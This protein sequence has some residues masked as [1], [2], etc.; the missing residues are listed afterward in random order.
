MRSAR[1]QLTAHDGG[2]DIALGKATAKSE[3]KD[4]IDILLKASFSLFGTF[5]M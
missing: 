4:D 3:T 5:K 1:N 2:V